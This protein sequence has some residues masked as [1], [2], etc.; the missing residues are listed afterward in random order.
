MGRFI[1]AYLVLIT[2]V[3][4]CQIDTIPFTVDL[5]HTKYKFESNEMPDYFRY[6][7]GGQNVAYDLLA[8]YFTIVDRR[9]YKEHGFEMR[10][11][12]AK[13]LFDMYKG[14][15]QISQLSQKEIIIA[16]EKVFEICF[17]NN[18]TGKAFTE[19]VV[20][21]GDNK[22]TMFFVGKA[23]VDFDETLKEFKA[24]VRSIKIK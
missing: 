12:I 3:C 17:V 20:V 13:E 21:L 5:S 2:S 14:I 16:N 9:N 1:T 6:T 11:Q 23:M 4:F 24:I 18:Y 15:K 7:V 22:A 8:N 10:K 19:Y